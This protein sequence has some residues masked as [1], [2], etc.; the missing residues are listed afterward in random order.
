MGIAKDARYVV[1]DVGT[2]YS[3]SCPRGARVFYLIA[4]H[5]LCRST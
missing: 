1:F 3:K 4:G 2:A 5:A